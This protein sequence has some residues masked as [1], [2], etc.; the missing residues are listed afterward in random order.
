MAVQPSLRRRSRVGDDEA[1]VAVGKGHGE[2][3]RPQLD[4]GDDRIRLAKVH[5]G[6]ARRHEHLTL[7]TVL[8]PNAILDDGVA[9]REAV[10][11]AETIEDPLR[12]MA[13]LT[14]NRAVIRQNTVNNI[15]ERI[16]LRA[17]C[18]LAATVARGLRIAEYLLHRLSRYAKP[19]RRLALAQ[20]INVACQTNK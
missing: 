13:L 19:T 2:K 15:R 16:Q 5:L 20:A 1:G 14:V 3:M 7:T 9:A 18:W 10:L 17:R 8:S 12:R 11:I 4:P 6:M